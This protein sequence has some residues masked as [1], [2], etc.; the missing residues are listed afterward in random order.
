MNEEQPVTREG[1]AVDVPVEPIRLLVDDDLRRSRLTVFFRLLLALPHFIVLALWSTLAYIIAFINWFAILF[2]GRPVSGL[3]KLQVYYLRYFTHVDSYLNLLADPFPGFAGEPRSY[4]IDLQVP[5]VHPQN[6]WKT[7]FRLILALPALLLVGSLGAGGL[8]V[9]GG[10]VRVSLGVAAFLGW[11]ASLARG[12]MPQGLRDLL[13]Y[14][15]GYSAQVAGYIFLVTDRYPNADPLAVQYP[16]PAPDHPVR[17]VVEEDLRR[18]RLTVFFRFFLF[19]PHL[20]WLALWGIAAVFAAVANWF[21]TLFRGRP[22]DLLHRFLST[23]LRYGIHVS[24]FLYLIAN[25]FPGFTGARGSYPV[26][27]EIAPPERQNRWKTGFRF[28]LAFPAGI[29]VSALGNALTLVA[30][31]AWFTGLI[32]G[33][34]PP[35]LQRLG[36]FAL[37]YQAQLN[38]YLYL[39]T[40]RYPYS[41]PSLELPRA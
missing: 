40:D 13:A 15:I 29:V 12:S 25:S 41:G 7:A 8:Q 21:V 1:A 6:R 3:H 39:L 24:A 38:A 20:I 34:I 5:G 23:Y 27:V 17:I 2:T 32:L 11:F 26:D 22:A 16:Q 19:L 30:V 33:R 9:G 35:G 28:I 14:A 36:V 37:R 10:S 18:S 31:F 4:P